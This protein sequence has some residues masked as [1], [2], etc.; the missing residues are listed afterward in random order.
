MI[1]SHCH[2]DL[3]AF[4]EDLHTVIN[5]AREN[6]VYGFL[7]PGTTEQGWQRQLAIQQQYRGIFL[8]FGW[9]PWFLPASLTTG[10]SALEKAVSEQRKR[11]VGIGEIGLDATI[12]IPMQVQE[13]WLT[14]QLRLAQAHKLPVVLHHLKTH[15]R[16]PALIKKSG[17]SYGGVIHG[18]SGNSHVAQQYI[19][20]GFKLGIGGTITYSRG[21]KTREAIKSVGLSSLLLETDSPDMPLHGFQGERNEPSRVRQVVKAMSDVLSLPEQDI[22][23]V[24]TKNFNRLFDINAGHE[25]CREVPF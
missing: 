9:H 19:D 17:F 13:T 4:N 2:L 18:Y 12:D 20:L 16:L 5:R 24:T 22:M 7:I 1:D 3:P 11:I 21:S 6:G 15:H 8:A 14:E 25:Y 10:L 23:E